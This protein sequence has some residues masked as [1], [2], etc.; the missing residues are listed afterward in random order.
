MNSRRFG[1]FALIAPRFVND[2]CVVTPCLNSKRANDATRRRTTLRSTLASILGNVSRVHAVNGR[3]GNRRLRRSFR[4]VNLSFQTARLFLE[5][6]LLAI[7]P[8]FSCLNGNDRIEEGCAESLSFRTRT[9]S[10]HSLVRA[11][12]KQRKYQPCFP[13]KSFLLARDTYMR[14]LVPR[15]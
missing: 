9:I 13:C 7:S 5:E 10:D 15:F 3:R 8:S 6:I 12:P 2:D 1:K 4:S 11:S 14:N